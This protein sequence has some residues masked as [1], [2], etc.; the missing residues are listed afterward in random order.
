MKII[1]PG[2]PDKPVSTL[3]TGSCP[4]CGCVFEAENREVEHNIVFDVV[5]MVMRCPMTWC[6]AAVSMI[7][8][9][10]TSDLTPT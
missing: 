9:P 5:A 6:R 3:Y 4:H 8:K 1:T 2:S 7:P 10:P